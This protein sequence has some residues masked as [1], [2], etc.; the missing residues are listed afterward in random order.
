MRLLGSHWRARQACPLDATSP[1]AFEAA[2]PLLT[3]SAERL[4]LAISLENLTSFDAVADYHPPRRNILWL[5][6]TLDCRTWTYYCDVRDAMSRFHNLCT[7]MGARDCLGG[8]RGF[9][10]DYVVV[11]PRYTAN[12]GH[13]DETLGFDRQKWADLPL[14]IMQNKMYSATTREIVGDA[15]AKLQWAQSTAATV[16]FTWLTQHRD[17]TR[18]SGVPHYWLP[19]GVDVSLYSQNSGTFGPAAQPYVVGFTGASSHKYPLRDAILRMV[20][21]MNISSYLGTWQQT[22]LHRDSN[23]SWKALDRKGYARLITRAR[24][25]VSTTGPS[26][27]VGTRYFEVLASG[28]T[29]LLC[30]R[31]P[32]GQ[33]VYD[34]LFED[35]KH[36]VMFD[37]VQDLRQKIEHYAND[38]A[39]RRRIV[40][41][42]AAHARR[43]HSWDMRARFISQ[44][45]ERVVQR[46]GL[47]PTHRPIAA[48]NASQHVV[49]TPYLGCFDGAIKAKAGLVEQ[50]LRRQLRRF[51]VQTCESVC[52]GRASF[53][54]ECGGFCSGNGHRLGRCWCGATTPDPLARRRAAAACATTCSLSDPRPCGGTSALAVY[55]YKQATTVAKPSVSETPA[56]RSSRR[57]RHGGSKTRG[58]TARGVA[59]GSR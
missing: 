44:A 7:P 55:S 20:R 35:G 3:P 30:N 5:E 59:A 32:P 18:R 56:P 36:V 4:A 31:P 33:H 1:A 45:L 23:M 39:A 13:A 53:A 52:R 38:E 48:A 41:A 54:L 42:A 24:M 34:G 29:L 28:T 6:N 46:G 2:M 8:R 49:R 22:S 15:D 57:S 12:V 10:P 16:A 43:V 51:T 14:A 37:S 21:R 25:W 17:F 27:I 26:H 50:K 9:R 58:R 47:G 11:G 19:F 40:L